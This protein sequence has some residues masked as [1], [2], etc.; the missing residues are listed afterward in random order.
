MN[1]SI[2]SMTIQ[3]QL[4]IRKMRT[5]SVNHL[6]CSFDKKYE[7]Y[8]FKQNEVLMDK[9]IYLGFAI[10]ELSKLLFGETYYD[11]L[12]PFFSRE[13][14]QL[15]YMACESFVMITRAQNIIDDLKNLED[16]FNSSNLD[17][18]HEFF[19]ERKSSK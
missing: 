11:K 7:S 3:N 14:I 1:N 15:F 18:N 8:T 19:S 5:S 12:Q 6:I 4:I 13:N 16:V 17:K 10:L 9:P 2:V